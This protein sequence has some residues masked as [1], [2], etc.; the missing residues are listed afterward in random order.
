M[1]RVYSDRLKSIGAEFAA[2]KSTLE[3]AAL[4]WHKQAL[5]AEPGLQLI[6]PQD[7]INAAANLEATFIIRLFAAFE[8]ILKEHMA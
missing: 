2:A 7:I 4:N 8:G 5:Y 6:G 1:S 3:Y